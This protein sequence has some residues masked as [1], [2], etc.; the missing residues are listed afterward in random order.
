MLSIVLPNAVH[1]ETL[2]KQSYER[3]LPEL[4]AL[5]PEDVTAVNIQVTSAVATAFGVC[6]ELKPF[7]NQII[8]QLP[9]FDIARFDKLEDYA[10]AL[11][12]ADITYTISTEP[13]DQL[14][15]LY[16]E[17]V[18]LRDILYADATAVAQ[19]GL[20]S[21]AVLKEYTGLTGYKNVAAE[22]MMLSGLLSESFPTIQGKCAATTE[23]LD[24]A[25][26]IGTY[27]L[28]VVGQ[29]EQGPESVAATTDMRAQA[30]TLFSRA[31]ADAR[32]AILFLRAAEQDADTIIPSL[33]AGRGG[34]KKKEKTEETPAA[35]STPTPGKPE[36][37][38]SPNANATPSTSG[39]QQ[40]SGTQP[41]VD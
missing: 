31:Y 13:D 14:R 27:I 28:R 34:S 18:R 6:R 9:Q 32:R 25:T 36:T 16:E 11:A 29:R 19:R 12:Q 26:R 22:L 20:V 35:T 23:E 41:F 21:S 2:I 30:F 33:Y 38:T 1:D 39:S 10:K 40:T 37:P 15:A 17:A 5:T 24:Q 8:E 7:R 3:I 4:K